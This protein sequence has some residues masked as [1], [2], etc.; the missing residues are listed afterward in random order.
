[1]TV[2]DALSTVSAKVRAR[3]LETVRAQLVAMI[4][5]LVP[6]VGGREDE[7]DE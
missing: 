7:H 4:V 2:R 3:T 6:K 5:E 1:M